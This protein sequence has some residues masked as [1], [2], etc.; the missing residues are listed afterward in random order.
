M[1]SYTLHLKGAE[2]TVRFT[3]K[4]QEEAAFQ[5]IAQRNQSQDVVF[6]SADGKVMFPKA[7]FISLSPIPEI[8]Q[9]DFEL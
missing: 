5:A 6:D 7:N 8:E 9:S 2:P 4:A 1:K 3:D